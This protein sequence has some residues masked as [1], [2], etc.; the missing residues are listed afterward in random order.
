MK[1]AA[2]EAEK[3]A[4]KAAKKGAEPA[5]AA[6]PESTKATISLDPPTGTRDFYP[7]EMRVRS[8]LFG[9]FREVARQF[10][11]QEYDAPVLEYDE[12]YKRKAGEEI[13][14]QMYNFI[15]K[16]G[17]SVTLRPEMTPSLA[18]MV[19]ALGG[20]ALLPLKWFSIPQ[21]WR[22]EPVQRGRKRE[23]YQWNMDIFG[24]SSI[25]A[26]LELLAAVVTFFERVGITAKDVGLKINSRAVLSAV[27]DSHG[28]AKENFAPVCVIVDKLDKIGEDGVVAEL[29]TKVRARAGGKEVGWG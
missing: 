11:F 21:C 25:S 16:D 1:K 13:T 2:K 27:L 10:A 22:F 17:H 5:A 12:L 29:L 6:A 14:G 8:W 18:R 20:K 3:A 9:H 4:K 23:H 28:I 15:D 7:Q 24:E 26:E 19:L